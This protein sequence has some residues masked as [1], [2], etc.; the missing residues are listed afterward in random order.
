KIKKKF[1]ISIEEIKHTR[2]STEFIK[3]DVCIQKVIDVYVEEVKLVEKS[4]DD[5]DT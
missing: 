1:K 3:N 2:G 5:S 4:K